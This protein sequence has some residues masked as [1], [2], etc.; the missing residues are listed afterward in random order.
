MRSACALGVLVGVCVVGREWEGGG[1]G[2]K[3]KGRTERKIFK[4]QG[5][6]GAIFL[7]TFCGLTAEIGTEGAP[8]WR[9]VGHH[10]GGL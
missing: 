3:G 2:W 5:T 9:K 7:V 4:D 1:R 10:T 8:S 6:M